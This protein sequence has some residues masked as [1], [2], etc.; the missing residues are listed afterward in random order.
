MAVAPGGGC[1]VRSAPVAVAERCASS[2]R[3]EASGLIEAAKE[4]AAK[5]EAPME[6]AMPVE[7][8]PPGRLA[9]AVCGTGGSSE[10]SLAA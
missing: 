6:A 10:V 4:E 9:R 2:R 5:E 3:D 7:A 8:A 1:G